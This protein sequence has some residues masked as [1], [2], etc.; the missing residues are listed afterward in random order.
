MENKKKYL[1]KTSMSINASPA[2]VWDALINPKL[3]KKYFF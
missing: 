3:I 1:A 2:K